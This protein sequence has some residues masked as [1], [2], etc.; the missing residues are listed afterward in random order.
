VRVW[1]FTHEP[2][3]AKQ[4]IYRLIDRQTLL[5]QHRVRCG[6][7]VVGSVGNACMTVRP[8]HTQCVGRH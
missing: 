1:E 4:V 2:H 3:N 5:L 7:M 8:Q 6:F